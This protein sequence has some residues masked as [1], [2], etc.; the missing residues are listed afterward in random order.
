VQS[1][2]IVKPRTAALN[3]DFG[4]VSTAIGRMKKCLIK[5]DTNSHIFFH[6]SSFLKDMNKR[7]IVVFPYGKH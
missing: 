5:R 7:F 6:A 2:S 1:Q 3:L 4:L